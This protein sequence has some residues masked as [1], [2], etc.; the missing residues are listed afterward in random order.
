MGAC[1]LNFGFFRTKY[2]RYF[3][4]ILMYSLFHEFYYFGWWYFEV[5]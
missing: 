3:T 5:F 4:E 1:L 2:V